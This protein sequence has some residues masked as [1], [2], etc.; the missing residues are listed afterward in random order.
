MKTRGKTHK[1]FQKKTHKT[2]KIKNIFKK[3]LTYKIR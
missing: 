3:I 1:I 2:L